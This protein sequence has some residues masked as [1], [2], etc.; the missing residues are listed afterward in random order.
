MMRTSLTSL[1]GILV[2]LAFCLSARA[3]NSGFPSERYSD[4]PER[5]VF[6][7]K[8][9]DSEPDSGPAKTAPPK[10]L[11]TGIT[12]VLSN[13]LALLKALLPT[14]PGT[15]AK[16]KPLMLAEGQRDG[17]IQVLQINEKTGSVRVNDSGTV[18]TLTFAKDGVKPTAGAAPGTASSPYALAGGAGAGSETAGTNAAAAPSTPWLTRGMRVLP[19]RMPRVAPAGGSTGAELGGNVTAPYQAAEAQPFTQPATPEA[20]N[21][22]SAPLTPQEQAFLQ[23]LDQ[24]VNQTNSPPPPPPPTPLPGQKFQLPQGANTQR[25]QPP[26]MTQ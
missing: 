9:A 20:T 19:T 12:T 23:Q 26:L 4:I 1:P 7:L 2:C 13:K 18:M 21:G 11:L 3:V 14:A 6:G 16:E 10:I 24:A 15:P 25:S 8:P 17:S 22:A 5:N